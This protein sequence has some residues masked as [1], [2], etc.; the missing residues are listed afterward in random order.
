VAVTVVL[1]QPGQVS[2]HGLG[3][4]MVGVVGHAVLVPGI[5]VVVVL[6]FTRVRHLNQVLEGH[7]AYPSRKQFSVGQSL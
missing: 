6:G 3:R 1:A 4:V 7:D 5:V 2:K